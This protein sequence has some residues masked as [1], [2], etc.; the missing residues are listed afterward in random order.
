[1]TESTRDPLAVAAAYRQAADKLDHA[2]DKAVDD[3][4]QCAAALEAQAVP[5]EKSDAVLV[6]RAVLRAIN[7]V[8]PRDN[9]SDPGINDVLAEL[10]FDP[11]YCEIKQA[12]W[13]HDPARC[14]L[15]MDA[16]TLDKFLA[17]C[18]LRYHD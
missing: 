14:L 1:M 7:N 15:R 11:N 6:A 8:M 10:G 3:L 5:K 2:A 12:E 16:G 9:G 18:L 17:W 4:L 13:A